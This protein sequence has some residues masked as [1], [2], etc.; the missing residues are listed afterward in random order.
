MDSIPTEVSVLSR[1]QHR[2]VVRYHAAFI[3][4]ELEGLWGNPTLS[5]SE[6][7]S[8]SPSW[9]RY[10]GSFQN[11]LDSSS[12]PRRYLY[13]QME[14][15]KESLRHW[16][17][18]TLSGQKS[19]KLV[20][21][22]FDDSDDPKWDIFGQLL[23]GLSYL[24][25]EGYVHRDLKPTNILLSQN[26]HVKIGDLGLARQLHDLKVD[27]TVVASVESVGT[28]SGMFGTY[29]YTAPELLF[30]NGS[31]PDTPVTFG[32]DMYACGVILLELW[33][34]FNTAMER[35]KTLEA[36]RTDSELPEDFVIGYP[37]QSSLISSLVNK[38]AAERPHASEILRQLPVPS[39]PLGSVSPLARSSVSMKSGMPP[40]YNLASSEIPIT[41]TAHDGNGSGLTSPQQ[42]HKNLKFSSSFEDK[43][44]QT[45]SWTQYKL[46]RGESLHLEDTIADLRKQLAQSEA[47]VAKLESFI[48]K[49]GL[50]I[51]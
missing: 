21:P 2:N 19:K 29:L 25:S 23:S 14:L 33:M 32:A 4:G 40:F 28:S 12:L 6:D 22:P 31:S 7:V 38:N 11:Q 30:G 10:N 13:I 1:L 46:M 15:C 18:K 3:A 44:F 5:D 50:G 47:R 39:Q 17:D 51:P 41:N 45:V 26:G 9:F 16:M 27:N 42:N 43:P 49:N 34:S 8:N 48:K 24:H 35:I 20:L 37:V 36:I